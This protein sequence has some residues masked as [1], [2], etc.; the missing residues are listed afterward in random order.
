MAG[1]LKRKACE[2][3]TP[4]GP[5]K[6]KKSQ[7]D[8]PKTSA[9]PRAQTRRS[10]L[11]LHDWITVFRFIDKHPKMLQEGVVQY[12]ETKVEGALVFTQATLS[13]NLARRSEL[14]A[15]V[16]THPNA[17]SSKRPRIVMRPDVE[18]ALFYWVKKMEEKGE[19]VNGHMLIEKCAR[20]EQQFDVPQN[21]QLTGD[22]WVRPFCKAYKIREFRRHGE[23]GSVN[24]ERVAAEHV[25]VAIILKQFAPRDRFNFDETSLFAF[26]PPDR[27]LATKQMSGKK[28]D[29]FRLT[30]GVACNTDG[31][32]KL[33]LLF[34]GKSARPRCFKSKSLCSEGFDYYN[35]KKAWMMQEIFTAWIKALDIRMGFER[36]YII[37]LIDNFSDHYISYIPKNIRI[38]FFEPNLTSFVQPYDA[39]IIRCL[40]AHYHRA[41]CLHALD[42]EEA[43]E[44]DI[45]KIPLNEAMLLAKEAWNA[46]SQET[47]RNCWKHTQIQP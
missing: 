23:A 9:K 25:R 42:L 16:D 14:E 40:K 37:L 24:L 31:S 22:G 7:K 35:N 15:C 11:T 43:D 6:H 26:A 4:Y 27:G 28:T 32:E 5:R 1:E 44:R 36:R 20:F 17:L 47:L 34:I 13:H 39:G 3:P 45:Y 2:K 29:K 10:N 19:T 18:K 38:E 21:E 8:L 33:K 30:L 41:F 46:V 12:F